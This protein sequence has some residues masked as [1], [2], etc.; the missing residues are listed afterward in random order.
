[1][2]QES[3]LRTA[4]LGAADGRLCVREQAK[5][6]ALREVWQDEGKPA[7]GMF[8][9][10]AS[11]VKTTLNGKPVGPSPDRTSIREFFDKIDA[12]GD[13]FPGKISGVKRGPKRIFSAPQSLP[14][15]LSLS[16]SCS[17]SSS[18]P[19]FPSSFA[20]RGDPAF[21]GSVGPLGRLGRSVGH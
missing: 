20:R 13:W 16:L 18:L 12:D 9:W 21:T 15:S 17:A 8:T 19:L 7:Y 10:I 14:L 2:S 1:M 5:A 11:R 6:W 3:S 4:W